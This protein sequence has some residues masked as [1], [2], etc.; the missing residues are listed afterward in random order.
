MNHIPTPP[1]SHIQ[2]Y[3]YPK[4][5]R[6][7]LFSLWWK[8][9]THGILC[10]FPEAGTLPVRG[11]LATPPKAVSPNSDISDRGL[12]ALLSQDEGSWGSNV[13][14]FQ[15]NQLLSSIISCLVKLLAR[16]QF[17]SKDTASSSMKKY[18]QR[19]PPELLK[20]KCAFSWSWLA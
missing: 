15:L 19:E 18:L 12:V 6:I 8:L 14:W 2:M 11:L 20:P 17:V 10:T 16:W 5:H 9:T 1:L 3:T 13:R 4:A 7:K